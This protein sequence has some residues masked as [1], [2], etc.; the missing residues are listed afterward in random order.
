GQLAWSGRRPWTWVPIP[1][2]PVRVDLGAVAAGEEG[3]DWTRAIG[4]GSGGYGL[5]PL[6]AVDLLPAAPTRRARLSWSGGSY[7]GATIAG[8]RVYGE[9]APGGGVDYSHPLAAVT[10]YPAG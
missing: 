2:G 7:L 5:D 10:A 8:F 4:Y 1:T 3:I 6:G 9:T